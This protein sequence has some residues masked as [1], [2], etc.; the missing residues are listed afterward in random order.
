LE[1]EDLAHLVAQAQ[2]GNAEAAF[3][4]GLHYSSADQPETHQAWS[5]R[6]A[7]L[8]HSVAQYNQWF[9][10]RE[11]SSCA[12]RAEALMWLEKAAAQGYPEALRKLPD[13]RGS[14]VDC[15]AE[16]SVPGNVPPNSSFKPMPLRGTA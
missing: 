11:T 5:R 8:G 6:A 4:V 3:R 12:D 14:T 10:L 1:A 16:P 13:Y 15:S 7:L 2:K 9:W